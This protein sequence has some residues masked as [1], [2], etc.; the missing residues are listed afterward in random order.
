MPLSLFWLGSTD[1]TVL[2]APSAGS[3]KV[4]NKCTLF[5]DEAGF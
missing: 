4:I 2:P 5:P 3:V 1:N